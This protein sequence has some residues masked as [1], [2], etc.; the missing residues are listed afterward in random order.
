MPFVCWDDWPARSEH[1]TIKRN[2]SHLSAI[3]KFTFR[4]LSLVERPD[5]LA[6]LFNFIGNRRFVLT[7]RLR[8]SPG[9]SRRR[10]PLMSNAFTSSY[11]LHL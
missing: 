3:E 6:E 4:C 10:I 9:K 2:H 7:N 5:T 8:S 1:P 11:M